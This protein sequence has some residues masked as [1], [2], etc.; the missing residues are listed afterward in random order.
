MQAEEECIPLKHKNKLRHTTPLVVTIFLIGM[1]NKRKKMWD[2][3]KKQKPQLT[4]Q[5]ERR[6]L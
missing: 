4:W 3:N 5:Q 2:K 1:Q 6:L